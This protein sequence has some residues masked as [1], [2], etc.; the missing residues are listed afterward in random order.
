MDAQFCSYRKRSRPFSTI[1]GNVE[2]LKPRAIDFSNHVSNKFC[3]VIFCG[4][5]RSRVYMRE[6]EQRNVLSARCRNLGSFRENE[7]LR[8]AWKRPVSHKAP[9]T[10][11][12]ISSVINDDDRLGC[13]RDEEK[14]KSGIQSVIQSIKKWHSHWDTTG[15]VIPIK[16]SICADPSDII[17]TEKLW[18]CSV[19]CLCFCKSLS[20]Q[21]SMHLY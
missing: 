5:G 11:K 13:A 4:C 9:F 16:F 8:L 7:P 14:I 21:L 12:H 15:H 3:I 6:H 18:S 19:G 20:F 2:S 17:I 10:L 1:S